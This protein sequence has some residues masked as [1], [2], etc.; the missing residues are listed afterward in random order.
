[1]SFCPLSSA[2]LTFAF[3]LALTLIFALLLPTLTLTCSTLPSTL[4]YF[5]FYS[6]HILPLVLF[7]H[8]FTLTITFVHL[9]LLP[10]L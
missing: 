6:P 3:M 8:L 4:L 10:S 1:M 7:Q 9:S 5:A 2:F